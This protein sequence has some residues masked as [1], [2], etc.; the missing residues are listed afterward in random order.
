MRQLENYAARFSERNPSLFDIVMWSASESRL[1]SLRSEEI[2]PA[3]FRLI[4]GLPCDR[5]RF[6]RLL[7]DRVPMT[8]ML[9][10]DVESTQLPPAPPDR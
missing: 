10:V 9:W 6:E 5:E 3:Q 8:V 7:A 2:G 1:H 4:A